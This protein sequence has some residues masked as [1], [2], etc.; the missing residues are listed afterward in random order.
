MLQI[1]ELSIT[2]FYTRND[3]VKK[4]ITLLCRIHLR[5]KIQPTILYEKIQTNQ[6]YKQYK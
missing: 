1:T 4:Y 5:N 3:Q 6:L 2:I